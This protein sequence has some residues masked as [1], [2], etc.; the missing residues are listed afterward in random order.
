METAT[1][2]YG[3][4]HKQILS[5]R[6]WK[7]KNP[8]SRMVMYGSKTD[9]TNLW[10]WESGHGPSFRRRFRMATGGA[11]KV[12]SSGAGNTLFLDTGGTEMGILILW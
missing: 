9:K 11:C 2:T 6:S 3:E 1:R 12:G 8:H 5:E 10:C 7:T 4:F